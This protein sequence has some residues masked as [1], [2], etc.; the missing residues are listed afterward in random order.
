MKHVLII[1]DEYDITR[2]LSRILKDAGY[3]TTVAEDG[4]KGIQ[5]F[6]QDPTDFK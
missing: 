1:D 3:K 5:H 6:C 2:L 4:R